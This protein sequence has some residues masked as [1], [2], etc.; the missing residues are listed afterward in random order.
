[1]QLLRSPFGHPFRQTLRR[2]ACVVVLGTP[3]SNLSVIVDAID[4]L[5]RLAVSSLTEDSY[6]RVQADVPAIIRTFTN[7][8]SNLET[9]M[10][11]LPVHWTDVEFSEQ[12]GGKRVEEV[13]VV[14]SELRK[15]LKELLEAFGG[16]ADNLGLGIREMRVARETA[17]LG[18]GDEL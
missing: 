6:G 13:D 9:F 12:Q 2:R 18:D 14:I 17:G 15:G 16:Y 7:T 5:T 10:Q 11:N 1:M 4:A 3:Y 8:I